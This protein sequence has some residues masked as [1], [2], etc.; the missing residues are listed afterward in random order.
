MPGQKRANDT[1]ATTTDLEARRNRKGAGKPAR[2]CFLGHTAMENR[3]GL[4]PA[5]TANPATGTAEREV[6]LSTLDGIHANPYAALGA[7]LTIMS[8]ASSGVSRKAALSPT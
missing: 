5:A 6:T 1:H 4:A 3:S 7:I 8:G 2:L